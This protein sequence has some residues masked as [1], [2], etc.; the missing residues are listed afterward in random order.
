MVLGERYVGIA[1]GNHLRKVAMD[2]AKATRKARCFRREDSIGSRLADQAAQSVPIAPNALSPTS[3][4][5]LVWPVVRKLPTVPLA[6][7]LTPP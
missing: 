6:E 5:P 4:G 1:A 7:Q 3:P 2:N